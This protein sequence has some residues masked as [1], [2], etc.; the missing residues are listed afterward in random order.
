A[1]G[2]QLDALARGVQ[3]IVGTPGRVLDH[4]NEGRLR[5]DHVRMLI[6]DEADE[7]LSLGFWPDM[8]EI[9]SFLPGERQTGLFSA[10]I[11]ER[12]RS[13][14]RNFLTDP[15]FISLTAGGVRSPEE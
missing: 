7:L 13:L 9:R 3:I 4:L 14:S 15:E 10:T 11:P 12:V 2:P 5:L 1:Y 8:K 6:F